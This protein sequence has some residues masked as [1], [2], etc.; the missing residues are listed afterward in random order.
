[1]RFM[2]EKQSTRAKIATSMRDR[3]MLLMGASIAGRG[4]LIRGIQLSD[5]SFK[6]IPMP[7]LHADAKIDVCRT[8]SSL[9]H[10]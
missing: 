2:E 10:H 9:S 1:M 4:E 8:S 7:E 6:Q 5:L 3:A